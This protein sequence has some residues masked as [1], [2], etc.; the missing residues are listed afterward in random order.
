[1][2]IKKLKK[3][4]KTGLKNN[5]FIK[6]KFSIKLNINEQIN[7][8]TKNFNQIDNEICK[9]N[10]GY[11]LTPSINKRLKNYNHKL[12][13]LKNLEKNHFIAI[14]NITKILDFKKYCKAE[15]LKFFSI[16][17]VL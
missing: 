2:Q 9:K 4:W 11:Y 13:M 12:Y 7:F 15:K 17:Q 3:K 8:V 6:E 10:W 5:I 14:V 16:T 1:M